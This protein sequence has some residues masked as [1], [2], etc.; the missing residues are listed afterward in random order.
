MLFIYFFLYGF[1]S[2]I[3]SSVFT[4]WGLQVFSSNH[5]QFVPLVFLTLEVK[6]IKW[7]PVALFGRVPHLSCHCL[8]CSDGKKTPKQHNNLLRS[9][10]YAVHIDYNYNIT[11]T[12]L[13]HFA[14]DKAILGFIKDLMTLSLHTGLKIPAIFSTLA[15]CFLYKSC[16]SWGPTRSKVLC[17]KLPLCGAFPSFFLLPTSNS[18]RGR[19]VISVK[20]MVDAIKT[21]SRSLATV[22]AW[23]KYSFKVMGVFKDK[24]MDL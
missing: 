13:S 12:F 3:S 2:L 1:K 18:R 24:R 4:F 11:W 19:C 16:W 9:L 6:L 22:S 8:G 7:S 14:N 5:T 20:I 21:C 17:V 23:E 15:I 10:C